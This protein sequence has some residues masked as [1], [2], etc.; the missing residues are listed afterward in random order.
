MASFNIFPE[1]DDPIV[2]FRPA[3]FNI[4]PEF[5][6]P[7]EGP[8]K[9]PSLQSTSIF[10][11]FDPIDL[12]EVPRVDEN[13]LG[14][15]PE[16]EMPGE[17]P[18]SIEPSLDPTRQI[19]EFEPP[20]GG[21]ELPA[22][23]KVQLRMQQSE[24]LDS[25][26]DQIVAGLEKPEQAL[27]DIADAAINAFSAI[28]LPVDL[29]GSLIGV[30]DPIG[31]S[32]SIKGALKGVGDFGNLW[33]QRITGQI[34][35]DEFQGAQDKIGATEAFQNAQTIASVVAAGM[36]AGQVAKAGKAF[37]DIARSDFAELSPSLNF[38]KTVGQKA[39]QLFRLT[40]SS[41][42]LINDL[43]NGK[44]TGP[45]FAELARR[46]PDLFQAHATLG[47]DFPPESRPIAGLLPAPGEETFIPPRS[48]GEG[49]RRIL[50]EER[51]AINI[52]SLEKLIPGS[53]KL[54]KGLSDLEKQFLL[55]DFQTGGSGLGLP[56]NLIPIADKLSILSAELF[57]PPP[58]QVALSAA[59][60][61]K[62]QIP[63]VGGGIPVPPPGT[64][65]QTS[66][67]AF[68]APP[69][70]TAPAAQ[71]FG[72]NRFIT[73]E[74][75]AIPLETLVPGIETIQSSKVAAA[76]NLDRI[77]NSFTR[78]RQLDEPTNQAFINISEG[79][80]VLRE[81]AAKSAV[82]LTQGFD[83]EILE[84]AYDHL[85]EPTKFP[86]PLGTEQMIENLRN[87]NKWSFKQINKLSL[88]SPKDIQDLDNAVDNDLPIPARLKPKLKMPKWPDN[89]IERLNIERDKLQF[90]LENLENSGDGEEL[91]SRIGDIDKKI[92]VLSS[93]DYFHQITSKPTEISAKIRGIK[94]TLSAKPSR[95]LG[96]KFATR[97]EA[98]E[99]GREVKS[100]TAA[101]ADVIY[102]ANRTATMDAFIKQI[103][104]NPDFSLRSDLAPPE[105]EQLNENIFPAGR[106]RKYNPAISEAIKEITD[107]QRA[108]AYEKVNSIAKIIGF[109]N[110][111]F[112][113]RFNLS[114][115]IRAAG[116]SHVKEL[117]EAIRIWRNKGE[118]YNDLRR[119]GLFNNVF[120]TTPQVSDIADNMM[121][122]INRE[123]SL[124][125]DFKRLASRVLHPLELTKTIWKGLNE[126][127]WKADEIQR[128]ATWS[129]LNKNKRLNRHF[130]K[131]E[132]VELANDFHANYAKL[133][134]KT[135]RALNKAIFTPTYKISMAR[136]L[137]R[138]H[139]EPKALWPSLLRHY[140][141]KLLFSVYMGKA[142]SEW[143]KFRGT[144]KRVEVEGYRI[145]LRE[146]GKRKETVFSMSDPLLE[147]KKIL[148]RP[149]NRTAEFN[150]AAVPS[151]ILTLIR[152]PLFKKTD[153]DW[154]D[155]INSYFKTGA[156]VL[157]ELALWE[158]NDKET[159]QKFMQLFGLAF[160][161]K[162]N[163][164][165]L[166]EE[167]FRE[168]FLKAL[169]LWVDFKKLAPKR[170]F[171]KQP[172]GRRRRRGR[173]R[174][175]TR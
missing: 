96:R 35:R 94:R 25:R 11:E 117:P 151:A 113:T 107:T 124:S 121:D 22:D 142:L 112:M 82:D 47:A 70:T 2:D 74:T 99:A 104:R 110:P 150:L 15:P 64:E 149:I 102:E 65:A 83:P 75:G 55:V 32:E 98:I 68:L 136:I 108:S 12:S 58:E 71:Q 38:A 139:R 78:F 62:K 67:G 56:E 81:E 145:V 159:Y 88:T 53:G 92:S 28:G 50:T 161:Y 33:L 36:A 10:P 147:E 103:N 3:G 127:T 140:G 171:E 132:I 73:E 57:A 29:V 160:I 24:Q 135:R 125:G 44:I 115:G 60:E 165:K 164:T 141:M 9:R 133:P 120:D 31:G 131:F 27:P 91:Q 37:I 146:P 158:E 84:Q 7:E 130:S 163:R 72:L 80:A 126:S 43:A 69:K 97:K 154:K 105:W 106:F 5:D 111:I 49:L 46:K 14:A 168:K 169:D 170:G 153:E 89:E 173:Q 119:N 155:V 52:K 66:P 39:R 143:L 87:M 118:T 42:S 16:F 59:Q 21:F 51:G 90:N 93:V 41:E 26:V 137:G 144:D 172:G 123:K 148:N 8:L 86:V 174:R 19:L 166:P 54:V 138:M 157:K 167:P 77:A 4:F 152:G 114:Q 162:R 109:Y 95:L 116:I 34:S 129:A 63:P 20:G 18:P 175:R 48:I 45:E 40:K 13:L 101:T 128:I 122:V 1:F 134:K 6:E 79:D 30:D 76:Q 61:T 17:P 100:L 156:P 85:Q 23:E